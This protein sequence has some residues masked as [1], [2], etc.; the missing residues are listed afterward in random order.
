MNLEKKRNGIIAYYPVIF[1][2]ETKL[3]SIQELLNKANIYPRR[4]FYPSL[5]LL[6]YT[7]KK[8]CPISENIA[9]R[10]LCLP[11]YHDLSED[12]SFENM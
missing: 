4:Y 1:K 10:V 3:L 7:D 6:P 12:D 11:L 5:N 2:T 9:S 8:S